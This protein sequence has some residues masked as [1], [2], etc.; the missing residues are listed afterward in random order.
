MVNLDAT[1]PQLKVLK[2]WADA[3]NAR[4]L[5]AFAPVLSKDFTLKL[6]PEAAEFPNLTGEDYVQKYGLAISSFSKADV[7]TRHLQNAF[8]YLADIYEP[9]GQFPRSD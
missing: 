8:K 6:L 7:R 5:K 9:L 1:T 3:I 2:Q 4:D